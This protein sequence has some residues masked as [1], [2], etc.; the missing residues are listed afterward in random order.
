MS[1]DVTYGYL[2]RIFKFKGFGFYQ[3]L[4][5]GGAVTQLTSKATGVTLNKPTGQITTNA[6]ALGTLAYVSFVVTDSFVQSTDVVIA[7]ISG[8]G[9]ANAYQVDVSAVTNGSFTLTLTNVTAGSLSEAPV[10]N[11]VV[12]KG[13]AN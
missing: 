8:G 12:V 7:C 1:G 10:I 2:T 6:A 13:A 11:F 3:G 9:T 4:G 5:S